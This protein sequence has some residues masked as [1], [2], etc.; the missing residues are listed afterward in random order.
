MIVILEDLFK[1]VKNIFVEELKLV[2][3][4]SKNPKEIYTYL[5][6]QS[7]PD[8]SISNRFH[9][10][11]KE[12]CFIVGYVFN[13][14]VNKISL[15]LSK[16]EGKETTKALYLELGPNEKGYFCVLAEEFL[17]SKNSREMR[18]KFDE[19]LDPIRKLDEI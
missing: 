11:Y 16:K 9:I 8:I 2:Y 1:E 6:K 10:P 5:I 19:K 12:G 7:T 4:P 15:I 17:E 3:N 13:N 14:R 18:Q